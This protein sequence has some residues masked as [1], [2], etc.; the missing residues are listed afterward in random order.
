MK[1]NQDDDSKDKGQEK[2]TIQDV[3]PKSSHS[4]PYSS[5]ANSA[6]SSERVKND[7]CVSVREKSHKSSLFCIPSLTSCRSSR[8]RRRKTSPAIAV[9]GKQ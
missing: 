3:L 9:D 1:E 5:R 6:S 2:P 8:E 7:D 4:T